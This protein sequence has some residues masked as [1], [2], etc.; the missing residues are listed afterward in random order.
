MP[1]FTKNFQ[2]MGADPFYNRNDARGDKTYDWASTPVISGPAGY[3]EQ[4]QD[5]AFTRF[6]GDIGVGLADTSPYARFVADQFRNAQLGH[7][8]LLADN[9]MLKFQ[10]YL[11][12]LGSARDFMN[13]FLSGT[14]RERGVYLT[15]PTRT[16]ADI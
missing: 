2:P 9:P 3:L 12:S 13:R 10:D 15:G 4:N 5:A 7:K 16:I 1:S 14:P 6:M 11:K 8:A